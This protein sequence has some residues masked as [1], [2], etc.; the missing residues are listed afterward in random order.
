[1]K[2]VWIAICAVALSGCLS[3]TQY[4]DTYCRD[5]ARKKIAAYN[6]CRNQLV[7]SRQQ[8]QTMDMLQRQMSHN[9]W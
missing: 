4:D 8:S 7:R 2:F 1:M 6:E 5:Q 9:K 3:A